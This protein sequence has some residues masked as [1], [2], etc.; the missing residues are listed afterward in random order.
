[1]IQ[2]PLLN[3][4][5]CTARKGNMALIAGGG[6][7]FA[8]STAKQQ[9]CLVEYSLN[10][11]GR[12]FYACVPFCFPVGYTW[13]C[14][15]HPEGMEHK[16]LVINTGNDIGRTLVKLRGGGP[17]PELTIYFEQMGLH[18]DLRSEFHWP[19]DGLPHTLEV[20]FSRTGAPIDRVRM[21]LDGKVRLDKFSPTCGPIPSAVT[22]VQVGAYRNQDCPR[23]QAFAIGCGSPVVIDDH[24]PGE[25]VPPRPIPPTPPSEYE[26]I[27]RELE[28][29]SAAQLKLAARVRALE[30]TKK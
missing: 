5:V 10:Q 4:S 12:E 28:V 19:T 24:R 17:S 29:L 11:A 14:N 15:A 13:D 7:K 27:A 9:S 2:D 6:V 21:W 23:D 22:S 1:M 18:D 8:L 20:L 26:L 30:P 16:L 25:P 3:W